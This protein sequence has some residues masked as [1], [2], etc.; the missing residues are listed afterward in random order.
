[1]R[2]KRP[3]GAAGKGWSARRGVVSETDGETTD[4]EAN[5]DGEADG[6]TD[7]HRH[8]HTHTHHTHTHTQRE[9]H[10]QQQQQQALLVVGLSWDV[11]APCGCGLL[12]GTFARRANQQSGDDDGLFQRQIGP[13]LAR[14]ILSPN[15]CGW[16][17]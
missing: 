9:T 7:R 1:M 8:R 15:W 5:T 6:E 16:G 4:G 14:A 12:S 2:Y 10:T 17:C 13:E 3:T 11:A